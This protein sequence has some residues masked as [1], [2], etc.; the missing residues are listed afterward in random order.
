MP[1]TT[2][3]L[4]QLV[5]SLT[6]WLPSAFLPAEWGGQGACLR[7]AFFHAAGS[8]RTAC[9]KED[10]KALSLAEEPFP[11]LPYYIHTY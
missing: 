1:G 11:A 5:P 3:P 2:A 4:P 6:L 8:V 9:R 7:H 10:L